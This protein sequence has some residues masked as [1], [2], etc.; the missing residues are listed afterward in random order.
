MP[1]ATEEERRR[2]AVA[3]FSGMAGVLTIARAF[4]EE[5]DRRWILEG[6]KPFFLKAA[7]A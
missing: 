7:Q 5:S 6:A 2:K 4:T 1:G 3:L